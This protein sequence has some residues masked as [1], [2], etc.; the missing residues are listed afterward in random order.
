MCESLFSPTKIS[1]IF[2]TLSAIKRGLVI[3]QCKQRQINYNN[4]FNP[5]PV[6]FEKLIMQIM[7]D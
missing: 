5:L 4:R 3:I 6:S 2:I 1:D 7:I